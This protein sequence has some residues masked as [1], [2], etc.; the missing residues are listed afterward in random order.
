MKKETVTINAMMEDDMMKILKKWGYWKSLKRGL[1]QCPCGNIVTEQN[2]AG[3][4]GNGVGIDFYH[5]IICV[6]T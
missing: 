1:I 5:S 3:M 4:K 2:L 6:K